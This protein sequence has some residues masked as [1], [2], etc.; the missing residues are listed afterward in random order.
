MNNEKEFEKFVE[1]D[2]T[3]F[4][5]KS[6]KL[7]LDGQIENIFKK[8]KDKKY[9]AE[10]M[11][12]IAKFCRGSMKNVKLYIF[13]NKLDEIIQESYDFKLIAKNLFDRNK[14]L[15]ENI[16][17]YSKQRGEIDEEELA[18][19]NWGCYNIVEKGQYN[20]FVQEHVEP[21]DW[22][23]AFVELGIIDFTQENEENETKAV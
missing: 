16:A 2:M 7:V 20:V 5:E 18:W 22:F 17:T 12:R 8:V 1:K 9:T 10:Q 3:E 4:L 14:T 23:E 6:F 13:K 21:I 19:V 11:E 15:N